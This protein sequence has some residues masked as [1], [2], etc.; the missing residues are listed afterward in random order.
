M[1]LRAPIA[2][3]RLRCLFATNLTSIAVLR[4]S[5]KSRTA[6]ETLIR[7]ARALT[8]RPV[9]PA[10]TPRALYQRM[11]PEEQAEYDRSRF[12]PRVLRRLKRWVS[13]SLRPL[14]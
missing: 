11:S 9:L 8:P 1:S 5:P 2:G 13:H 4:S 3:K 7:A 14:P 10:P 6:A 12:L